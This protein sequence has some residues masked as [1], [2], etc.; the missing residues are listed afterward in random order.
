MLQQFDY[1]CLIG[2]GAGFDFVFCVFKRSAAFYNFLH[3]CWSD[4]EAKRMQS[5]SILAVKNYF[6]THPCFRVWRYWTNLKFR[7]LLELTSAF[8]TYL[9]RFNL[10]VMFACSEN[11]EPDPGCGPS[12]ELL[13]PMTAFKIRNRY[14]SKYG[15][16]LF[17]RNWEISCKIDPNPEM[18][19]YAFKEFS[20]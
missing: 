19:G 5:R 2:P 6:A 12:A 3:E 10:K 15:V 9:I 17:S 20:Y 4:L 8:E 7:L 11:M 16:C 13:R 1:Y 14:Y 18:L